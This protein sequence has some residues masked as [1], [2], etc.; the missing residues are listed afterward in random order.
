MPE[1]ARDPGYGPLKA[2]DGRKVYMPE[3]GQKRYSIPPDSKI[4]YDE[5][6]ALTVSLKKG[7]WANIIMMPSVAN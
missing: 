3:V 7:E 2:Y 1:H 6:L 5:Q 4:N